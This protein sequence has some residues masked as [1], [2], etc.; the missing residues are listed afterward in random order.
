MAVA[1][2]FMSGRSQAVRLPK[3]FRV[4]GNELAITKVGR[5]IVLTPI[6]VGW[7]DF[8]RIL[9]EFETDKPI[10]RNQPQERQEREPLADE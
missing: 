6:D 3:E 9:Q 7:P 1:K 10:E 2:V 8:F 4:S 5:S